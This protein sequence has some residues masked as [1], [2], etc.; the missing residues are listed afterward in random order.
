MGLHSAKEAYLKAIL[1]LEKKKGMVRSIDIAGH[2]RVSRPSVSHEVSNLKNAVLL[3][4]D[5]DSFL[6]LTKEAKK[7]AE[8][9]YEKHCFFTELLVRAGVDLMDAKYDA[10]RMRHTISENIFQLLKEAAEKQEA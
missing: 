10:C 8:Q 3:T 4:M 6:H 1:V 7:I 5:E 2:I 9:T